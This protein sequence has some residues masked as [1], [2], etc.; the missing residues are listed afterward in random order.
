MYVFITA[1]NRQENLSRLI[2][3]L[4]YD[5]VVVIDDHSSPPLEAPC[6]II[7]TPQNNGKEGFWKNINLIF[8]YVRRH[9]IN[10]FMIIPDDYIPY[11]NWKDVLGLFQNIEN[12]D[13]RAV[14]M[15]VT[16]RRWRNRCWTG[17]D[18]II[19]KLGDKEYCHTQYIDGDFI[20]NRKFLELL[21]FKV[22][23]VTQHKKGRSSG[24]WKQV[25]ERI[26]GNNGC[27]MY[28][29]LDNYYFE[30][31]TETRKNSMM[32]DIR[33]KSRKVIASC[34]TIPSR[35]NYLKKTI[36]SLLN[37]VDEVRCY[38]NGFERIPSFLNHDK[39]KV[40]KSQDRLGD[41]TDRGKFYGCDDIEGYH[42][43]FDDDIVYPPDYVNRLIHYIDLYGGVWSFHGRV[44]KDKKYFRSFYRGAT[45]LFFHCRLEMNEI[46]KLDTPGTG[47][48]GYHTD[49]VRFDMDDFTEDF[50]CDILVAI[51]CKKEGIVIRGVPH[52]E[53]LFKFADIPRSN[54]IF[55]RQKDN[56]KIQV[57]LI[58]KYFGKR[59]VK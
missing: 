38:L 13:N 29:V 26:H 14:A 7:R 6:E 59:V 3:K 49:D 36:D 17:F 24:V 52:E 56:D 11:K 42:L 44:L 4:N 30:M 35:E 25:S 12:H 53:G 8:D 20:A 28:S 37:Q 47:V 51:K 16:H 18:K 22:N 31:N 48:M 23:P 57:S 40:Y 41:I 32:H 34:A 39:I 43:T 45:K 5:K 58:N 2:D 1:Y 10:Y 19:V 33:R 9:D 46:V 15:S 21:H 27:N 55:G 54:T 50:M